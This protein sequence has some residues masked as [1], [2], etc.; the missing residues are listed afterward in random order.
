M[1]RSL[2]EFDP[3]LSIVMFDAA[4][5]SANDMRTHLEEQSIKM[6]AHI[7]DKHHPNVVEAVK[8][9]QVNL[10]GMP[11]Q[12]Y[13]QAV[14]MTQAIDIAY[15]DAALYYVQRIPSELGLFEWKID[16][17]DKEIT[18]AEGWWLKVLKGFLQSRRFL[19]SG[20]SPAGG[21]LFIL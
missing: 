4:L 8:E 21:G 1:V 19:R 12:L 15:R 14:C 9:L 10:Q 3:V 6:M 2:E 20:H 17:R 13:V 16:R 18:M 5:N 11:L 7:T